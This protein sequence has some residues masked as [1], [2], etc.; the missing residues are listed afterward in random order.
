M[1]AKL[2]IARFSFLRCITNCEQKVSTQKKLALQTECIGMSCPFL[3]NYRWYLY[4]GLHN[5]SNHSWKEIDN[6]DN[7]SLTS[8]T[9]PSLVIE[10]GHMLQ[11]QSALLRNKTY[12]I[13][14]VAWLDEEN[15]EKES[16]IFHTNVPPYT[17]DKSA[18]C[19]VDPKL[20]EAIATKFTVQCVNWTDADLPISY[21]FSYET[22]FGVVV[23]HTGQQ[24]NV[25]TELPMGKQE[26]NYS[27]HLQLEIIDSFGDYST[28]FITVQV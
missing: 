3:T 13:Q 22:Q 24:P 26:S 5:G 11:N 9:G 4:V 7:I 23:F 8:L 17:R 20:G 6:L 15:Y 12:K 14:V 1:K 16:Y 28:V 21:Q 19:F 25:T 27:L 18:G 10:G 2:L